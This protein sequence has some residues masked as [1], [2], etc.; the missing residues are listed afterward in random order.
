M[1]LNKLVTSRRQAL[2]TGA[3]A[4]AAVVLAPF[5]A[6]CSTAAPSGE[7]RAVQTAMQRFAALQP[8]SSH[9]LVHAARAQGAPVEWQVQH[10]P[11]IPLF[12]GSVVKTFM[13]AQFLRDVEAG[14]RGLS[15][16]MPCEVSDRF[17]SPG[18]PVLVGLQGQMPYRSALEAMIAHSDNTAT[19]IVLDAVGADRVR[20][21]IAQSG[22]RATRIPDSTRKLFSYLAGASSGQDLGWD[23]MQRMA[24]GDAMGLAART[25]VVNGHQSM[26]STAAEMVHWYR[27]TLSPGFFD[28]ASTAVE[29][30]RIHAM[31]N[32]LPLVVPPGLAS[33]GKGGSLDWE[34]FHCISLA[35]QMVVAD[36]LV[37]F[38]FTCNWNGGPTSPERTA[39]FVA[40]VK[41]VLDAA[42]TSVKA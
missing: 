24:R 32:A 16:D 20:A 18:S 10:Q 30:R 23:G 1:V 22:L 41:Q 15:E 33:Y 21:L 7:P 8:H 14:H 27:K 26:V 37:T 28:R 3:A 19:D 38:C 6:S 12:V 34:G 29:Y 11:D 42:A 2:R 17:R 5:V 39:D 31:A 35:G 13:A 25:D 40:A 4:G 9:G 36:A